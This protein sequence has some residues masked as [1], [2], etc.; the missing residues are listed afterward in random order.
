MS[1]YRSLDPSP[2]ILLGPGP[3]MA[4]PRT[5]KAMSTPLI[6]HLD[7]EFIE[8]M[9]DVQGLLRFVFQTENK[10]TFPVSGTG[11]ASMESAL[12]NFIEPGDPVLVAVRKRC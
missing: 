8:I 4:S 7:P 10:L 9:N 6:G 3:S 2:R 1:D 5:L 11:S 12:C